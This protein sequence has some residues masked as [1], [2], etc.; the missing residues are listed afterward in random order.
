[1]NPL[2]LIRSPQVRFKAAVVIFFGCLIAWPV[3]SF[4]FAKQEPQTILGLSWGAMLLTAI[5]V[6][7]STD[8]RKEIDDDSES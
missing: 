6:M 4:T 7:A 5:D 1:M 3:S 8:I 2:R